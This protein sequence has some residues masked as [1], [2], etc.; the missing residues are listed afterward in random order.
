MAAEPRI[1]V[2]AIL[3]WH[4]RLLLC[5]HEKADKEYWL[6][7]GGGVNSGES[8]VDALHRE[9]AEEIGIDEEV[10]VEGP[11]AIVDSISP[12]RSFAPKH[13]VHIIFAGDLG[14]H[15]LEAVTSHDAA[16]RG[17]RLFAVDELEAIVLHPPIQRFLARWQ[18]GDPVVYLGA[19][20]AP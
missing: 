10:R 16:V 1:R 7:P 8:L 11:V 13:V 9:L 18:P 5:R 17:H 3:R 20:W 14:G 12:I 19:L 4:G 6:L 2:S 15:S